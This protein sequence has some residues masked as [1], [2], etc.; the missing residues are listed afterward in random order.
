M[1]ESKMCDGWIPESQDSK[2]AG[3]CVFADAQ[4][5]GEP[6]PFRGAGENQCPDFEPSIDPIN[7]NPWLITTPLSYLE[8]TGTIQPNNQEQP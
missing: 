6:C 7:G 5:S 4:Y 2:L 1:K 3:C 8:I